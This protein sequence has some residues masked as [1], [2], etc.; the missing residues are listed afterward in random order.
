MNPTFGHRSEV[1][2]G[3]WYSSRSV[4]V[5]QTSDVSRYKITCVLWSSRAQ[6]HMC[7]F[8]SVTAC[9]WACQTLCLCESDRTQLMMGSYGCMAHDTP[10]WGIPSLPGPSHMLGVL[11]KKKILCCRWPSHV[12][13]SQEP[14]FFSHWS[15]SQRLRGIIFS[16]PL[17]ITQVP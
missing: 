10:W 11:L 9:H 4:G 3:C 14:V 7:Y 16:P 13:E 5:C 1:R 15:T 2:E 6:S 12:P 8:Q 17:I